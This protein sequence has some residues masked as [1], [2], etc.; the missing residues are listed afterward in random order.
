MQATSRPGTAVGARQKA[1]YQPVEVRSGAHLSRM[2]RNTTSDRVRMDRHK[3]VCSRDLPDCATAVLTGSV[4][5][6]G[7]HTLRG[8]APSC[9]RVTSIEP[10][11][12]A[13]SACNRAA[14]WLPP[15]WSFSSR[16][17]ARR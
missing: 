16:L 14:L 8:M 9:E 15:R 12:R 5:Q 17:R 10:P 7:H 4:F 11:K 13:S 6:L 3:P 1:P 2:V